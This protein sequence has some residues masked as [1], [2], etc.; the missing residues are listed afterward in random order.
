MLPILALFAIVTAHTVG[1]QASTSK[2]VP[3]PGPDVSLGNIGG[4][5]TLTVDGKPMLTPGFYERRPTVIDYRQIAAT[6]VRLFHVDGNALGGDATSIDL[7]RQ[8]GAWDFSDLDKRISIALDAR[9]DAI[10]FLRLYVGGAP[11]WWI[12][13][14]PVT[15][16]RNFTGDSTYDLHEARNPGF[17]S[18]AS[19]EW[20]AAVKD[21]IR[22]VIDHLVM[23]PRIDA[24]GRRIGVLSDRI[25]GFVLTG[26]RSQEWYPMIPGFDEY[27]ER[28][29]YIYSEPTKEAFRRWLV[30]RYGTVETLSRAWSQRIASFDAVEPPTP[31][32]LQQHIDNLEVGTF[33]LRAPAVRDFLRFFNWLTVDTI[34]SFA[35]DIKQSPMGNRLVLPLYGYMNEFQGIPG[36]GHNALSYLLRSPDIDG[37]LVEPSYFKRY[38]LQGA[39][40][41]RSPYRSV[42]LAAKLVMSDNDAGTILT[43]GLR[44]RQC[45]V[46]RRAGDGGNTHLAEVWRVNC[47]PTRMAVVARYLDIPPGYTGEQNAWT[48]A[49]FAG[50]ALTHG[51]AFN[52]ASLTAGEY[53][54]PM[55]LSALS[56]LNAAMQAAASYPRRSIA[57]ILVVSSENSNDAVLS[58]GSRG[59]QDT[60]DLLGHSLSTPRYALHRMGTP[61]DHVLLED[62]GKVDL[63]PYRLVIFLNAFD[64]SAAE[65]HMIESRVAT[66]DR[67]V[68]FSYAAGRLEGNGIRHIGAVTAIAI[69]DSRHEIIRAPGISLVA[70]N[71]PLANEL[72]A[73]GTGAARPRFVAGCCETFRGADPQATVLGVY[74]GTSD[75]SLAIKAEPGWTSVWAITPA[76]PP[77]WYRAIAR[78]AG[79]HI[80]DG[81]N[82]VLEANESF[83]AITAARAGL[84]TITLPISANLFDQLTGALVARAVRRFTFPMKLGET[85]LFRFEPTGA[86]KSPRP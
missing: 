33:R 86:Q 9:P 67:T 36:Y 47:Q 49:R 34:L 50:F 51:V 29:P 4:V 17:P 64:L 18:L 53:Q 57:Q 10:L 79:V 23:T 58:R 66:G 44:D 5:T 13:S 32:E 74:P 19:T 78:Y 61:Y 26:W 42:Q 6:G 84:H 31:T 35:S 80:Y 81:A 14:H 20:R 39:D 37:I 55:L 75:V 15:L 43:S 1:S 8:S 85:R 62:L 21:G 40:L 41:E 56:Q 22:R 11:R 25:G 69:D 2:T 70:A 83:L 30:T 77:E 24:D 48:L 60:L 27:R 73:T 46:Y 45:D 65:R 54:D 82:D 63:T 16:E 3:V 72:T 28:P 38:G 76:L 52:Y 7:E 68:M 59:S 12:E 71:H